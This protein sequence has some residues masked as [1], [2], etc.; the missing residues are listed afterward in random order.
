MIDHPIW[1][2]LKRSYEITL[3]LRRIDPYSPLY[4][5]S[6]DY[7]IKLVSLVFRFDTNWCVVN[8]NIN[9]FRQKPLYK[10]ISNCQSGWFYITIV[11]LVDNMDF[12]TH[13]FFIFFDDFKGIIY[14]II[15]HVISFW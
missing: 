8:D 2:N 13:Y 6:R 11:Y 3:I 9:S 12:Y 5:L 1:L 14:V 10:I 7:L 15:I 4:S